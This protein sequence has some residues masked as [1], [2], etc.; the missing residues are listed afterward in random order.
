MT[1]NEHQSLSEL[2]LGEKKKLREQ[3]KQLGKP[4]P[5]TLYT[6]EEVKAGVAEVEGAISFE[7]GTEPEQWKPIGSEKEIP[8][9]KGGKS[10]K[11]IEELDR[12]IRRALVR[13]ELPSTKEMIEKGT[14]PAKPVGFYMFRKSVTYVGAPEDSF[15]TQW[16][17]QL[18]ISL[19]LGKPCYGCSC[20]KCIVLY[21]VLEGGKDY[22]LERIEDKIEAMDVDRDEVLS[23]LFVVDLTS[24]SLKKEDDVSK[25]KEEMLR[26]P[27]D[28]IFLDPISTF[29]AED[30]RFSPLRTIFTNNLIEVAQ[31]LD[32]AIVLI[33]H[34]RKATHDNNNMD[35]IA[36]HSVLKNASATRIKLF[37]HKDNTDLVSVYEKTRYAER[38]DKIILRWRPPLLE[39]S[40]EELK[41]RQEIE[42]AILKYL[43][44]NGEQPLTKFTTIIAK[45]TEH[46]AKTVRAVISNLEMDG[47]ITLEPVPKSSKKIVK[48]ISA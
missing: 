13:Q 33:A 41:P 39:M 9:S 40:P 30:E 1:E 37:R 11:T 4:I 25:L 12:F 31:T 32:A 7:K 16:A 15:K 24:R 19:A 14:I 46:N 43:N 42:V 2:S 27:A 23:N 26:I 17:I 34:C 5:I 45:N 6:W 28:V 20:K 38:P 21:V 3:L 47:K 36:G 10:V 48:K 8:F 35:E 44:E 22:I 18:A 29:L